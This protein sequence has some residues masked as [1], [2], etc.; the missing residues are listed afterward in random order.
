MINYNIQSVSAKTLIQIRKKVLRPDEENFSGLYHGDY[1]SDSIHLAA[2][3]DQTVIGCVSAW[4]ENCPNLPEARCCFRVRALAVYE[5]YRL[6]QIAS[7]LIRAMVDSLECIDFDYYWLSGR[8]SL[9]DFYHS[10]GFSAVGS[11]YQISGTGPH[12][13]FI[14]Q[15]RRATAS[16]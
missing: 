14:K 11:T 5:E 16:R 13:N 1:N 7:N 15:K 3:C 2:I 12:I 6:N 4:S 8:A 9:R 10:M